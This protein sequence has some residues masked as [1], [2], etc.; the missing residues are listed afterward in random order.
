MK[1]KTMLAHPIY[2]FL[3]S[4]FDEQPVV[5]LFRALREA[6]LPVFLVSLTPDL[7][8]SHWGLK[9]HADFFID[10][11]PGEGVPG[12]IF[13]P[14]TA[15]CVAHLVS[16]PRVDRLLTRTLSGGGFVAATAEGREVLR[17]VGFVE[18]VSLQELIQDNRMDEYD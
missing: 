8:H 12:L 18:T 4:D 10:Q 17:K 3:A 2:I 13:L 9:L 14:G 16:D 15:T 5:W 11:L 1:K 7:V 6:H